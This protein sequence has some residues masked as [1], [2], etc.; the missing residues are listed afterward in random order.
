MLHNLELPLK[1]MEE[2]TKQQSGGTDKG[3]SGEKLH[4]QPRRQKSSWNFDCKL[5]NDNSDKIHH[6]NNRTWEAK[7]QRVQ[8]W[9]CCTEYSCVQ[10]PHTAV[11]DVYYTSYR[12]E[13]QRMVPSSHTYTCAHTHSPFPSLL[14][15]KVFSKTLA[16][17]LP[18]WWNV[19][20]KMCNFCPAETSHIY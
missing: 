16:A 12:D 2:N 1:I 3:M 10:Q 8:V 13:N 7:H 6:S 19:L 14:D 15:P 11:L 18:P 9:L 4:L 5:L 20:M 17:L